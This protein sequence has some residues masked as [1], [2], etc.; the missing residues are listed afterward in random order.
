[1]KRTFTD[2][3][4]RYLKPAPAGKRVEHWDIKVPCFGIR[5][6]DKGHKT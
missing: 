2:R 6:T 4:V 5:V 3:F 1:M